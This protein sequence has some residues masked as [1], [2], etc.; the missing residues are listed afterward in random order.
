M[1]ERPV[2]QMAGKAFKLKMCMIY[3][4]A[5]RASF[6]RFMLELAAAVRQNSL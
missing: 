3:F 2:E 4:G 1:C 5:L 6:G